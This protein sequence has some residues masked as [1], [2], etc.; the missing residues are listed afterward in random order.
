MTAQVVVTQIAEASRILARLELLDAFGHVSARRPDRPD[1][2]LM[3]RSLAPALVSPE[4]IGE[5][6]YDGTCTNDPAA[7]VFLERFIHA[8]IYRRRPDVMAIVHSHSPDVVPYTVVPS[9]G[10]RPICHVC[11]FLQGSPEPF[12]IRG[13]AGD[14]SD[15]LIRNSQLGRALAAHLGEASVVLMRGHGFTT[16]GAS[17]PQATF[18][19]VYTAR[20]C[21]IDAIARGL[22]PPVYLT[23]A[24]AAA[25][26]ST[27]GGQVDRAWDLWL[28]QYGG[29]ETRVGVADGA[30]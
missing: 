28:R 15:L 7:R 19:A 23:S 13:H 24:E 20:N 30:V 11:G 26:E 21:R 9:A 4:D 16:V 2:F 25:C 8:E 22:G 10:L 1:R 29:R 3:S 12:D 5:L 17:V 6:D 18:R 27:T 14:D